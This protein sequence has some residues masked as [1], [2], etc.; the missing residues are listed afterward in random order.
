MSAAVA[1]IA[2]LL[3]AVALIAP[4]AYAHLTAAAQIVA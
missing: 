4:L 2:S 1:K 3:A